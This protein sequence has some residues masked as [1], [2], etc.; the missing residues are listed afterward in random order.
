MLLSTILLL[1]TQAS[2]ITSLGP[3]GHVPADGRGSISVEEY[4]ASREADLQARSEGPPGADDRGSITVEEF[5]AERD[6]KLNARSDSASEDELEA[7][8]PNPLSKRACW[9]GNNYGC[10]KNYCYKRCGGNGQ[11]CWL[12]AGGG[13]GPWLKCSVDSQC[14]PGNTRGS[15]CGVGDCKAC[16]CSC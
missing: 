2:M 1:A 5:K 6:A 11:W 3:V 4:K 7:T 15:G 12:A 13:K 16:G 10:S 14:S 9:F 8:S